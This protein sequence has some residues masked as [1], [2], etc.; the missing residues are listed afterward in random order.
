MLLF[1]ILTC[2]LSKKIV[3]KTMYSDLYD[4]KPIHK[5]NI[6]MTCN[7]TVDLKIFDFDDLDNPIVNEKNN[8][9]QDVTIENSGD[10]VRSIAY[11]I[12]CDI[13]KISAYTECNAIFEEYKIIHEDKEVEEYRLYA[14]IITGAT[15]GTCLLVC[16]LCV[17]LVICC[18]CIRKKKEPNAN[19]MKINDSF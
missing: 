13:H 19:Y 18:C 6:F 4:I 17:A 9:I 2:I 7:Q 16:V 12:L 3:F 11:E 14:Y 15:A 1:L 8:F 10:D 5:F